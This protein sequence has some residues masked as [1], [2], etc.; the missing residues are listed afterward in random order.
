MRTVKDLPDR[1]DFVH[2]NQVRSLF[3]FYFSFIVNGYD[4]G[5][6]SPLSMYHGKTEDSIASGSGSVNLL[7]G[8]L[9]LENTV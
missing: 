1:H 5:H 9:R 6:E 2:P 7:A 4:I 3:V 8:A